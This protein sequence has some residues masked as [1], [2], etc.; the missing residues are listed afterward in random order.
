MRNAAR[1]LKRTSQ[2]Y[3]R[4][5]NSVPPSPLDRVGHMF[6]LISIYFSEAR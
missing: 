1:L 6:T 2:P 3:E 5:L 4:A